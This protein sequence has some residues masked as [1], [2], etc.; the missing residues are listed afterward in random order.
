MNRMAPKTT[1]VRFREESPNT[2]TPDP[3]HVAILTKRVGDWQAASALERISEL[4]H[5]NSSVYDVAVWADGEN[6]VRARVEEIG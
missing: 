1:K 5:N 2:L 6:L 3:R 4:L